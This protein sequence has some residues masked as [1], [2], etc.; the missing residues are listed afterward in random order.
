MYRT[1]PYTGLWICNDPIVLAGRSDNAICMRIYIMHAK[2]KVNGSWNDYREYIYSRELFYTIDV[3]L[4][5][6]LP[7]LRVRLT[8][9]VPFSP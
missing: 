1:V 9:F 2:L 7:T 5:P 3:L 8:R 6:R 4:V